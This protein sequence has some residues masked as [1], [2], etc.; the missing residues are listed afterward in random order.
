MYQLHFC[1]ALSALLLLSM[2]S[3]SELAA[4]FIQPTRLNGIRNRQT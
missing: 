4:E 1:A 2:G 3:G